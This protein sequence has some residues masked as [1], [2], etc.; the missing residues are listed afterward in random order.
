MLQ[1]PKMFV[2]NLV[3]F[4][5]CIWIWLLFC[6]FYCSLIVTGY[7]KKFVFVLSCGI[8]IPWTFLS[9]SSIT[10]LLAVKVK[11]N[12]VTLPVVP[13]S[14][15]FLSS[16]FSKAMVIRSSDGEEREGIVILKVTRSLSHWSV[17]LLHVPVL[18]A[19][20]LL[21]MRQA[22]EL[23]LQSSDILPTLWLCALKSLYLSRRVE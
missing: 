23:N 6:S 8:H 3:L 18:Y 4:L 2:I 22:G 1:E 10:W 16:T 21:G 20:S 7:R 11:L 12:A 15:G 9:K 13:F 19:C 14:L 17:M 5:V